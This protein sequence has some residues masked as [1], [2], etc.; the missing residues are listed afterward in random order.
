M[1]QTNDFLLFLHSG[2]TPIAMISGVGLILLTLNNRLGRTVDR[3]RT[4]I[5]RIETEKSEKKEIIISELRILYKRSKILRSSIACITF[6]ILTSSLIVALL[7]AINFTSFNLIIIGE[8]L[9]ALSIFGIIASSIFLFIDIILTLKALKYEVKSY[10][11][12]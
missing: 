8:S 3:S 7:L 6:S 5:Y 2:I 9:F 10:I 11:E 1:E 4:L 12:T